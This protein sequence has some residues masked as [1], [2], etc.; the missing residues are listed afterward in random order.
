MATCRL[1]WSEEAAAEYIH[2]GSRHRSLAA[3]L[4]RQGTAIR[5][6]EADRLIS[7]ALIGFWGDGERTGSEPPARG[8]SSPFWS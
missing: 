6:L 4:C 8:R 7:K 5:G 2:P 3:E 1:S